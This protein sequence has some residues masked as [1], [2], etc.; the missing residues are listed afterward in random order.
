MTQ[1][2]LDSELTSDDKLWALLSWLFWPV[3][4]IVLL[5]EDKKNQP[6]IKYNAV[7]ALACTVL[8]YVIGTITVGCGFIIGGL[9]MLYLAIMAFQGNWVEV[10][11]LSG[12][13]KDQGWV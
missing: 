8:V 6:F 2:R 11:W 3:A 12:F 5:M 13:V 9:Y 1:H 4:I 10:P 7:L